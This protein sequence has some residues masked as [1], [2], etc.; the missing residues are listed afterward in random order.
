MVRSSRARH[1]GKRYFQEKGVQ[2]ER[3]VIWGSGSKCVSFLSSIGVEE[4]VEYVVDINPYRQGRFLPG[5]GIEIIAP[6]FLKKYRPD[7]IIVMNPIY[8]EEISNT[9]KEMNV[10]AELLTV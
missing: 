9:L 5:S 1:S 8:L 6:E 7:A 3:A 4:K 2:G 10:S